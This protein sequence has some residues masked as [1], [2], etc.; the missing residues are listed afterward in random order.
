MLKDTVEITQKHGGSRSPVM[1]RPLTAGGNN[2]LPCSPLSATASALGGS[3]A[4]GWEWGSFPGAG[5]GCPDQERAAGGA[6]TLLSPASKKGW[7]SSSASKHSVA[8]S[9]E[10]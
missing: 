7:S 9:Y 1:G 4:A 5:A 8:L 2:P 3:R 10:F 6:W